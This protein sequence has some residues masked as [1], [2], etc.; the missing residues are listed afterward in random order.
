MPEEQ[1]QAPVEEQETPQNEATPEQEG[2][3]AA[4]S[5]EDSESQATDNWEE[6][7]QHLQPEY[8]RATQELSQYKQLFQAAQQGDP[9]ALDALGLE[10]A[11]TGDD[12]DEYLDDTERLRAELDEIKQFLNSQSQEQQFQAQEEQEDN[13]ILS[14]LTALESKDNTEL[15]D[16]E[17]ELVLSNA[18]AS[19][20][21]TGKPNVESAYKA[22]RAAQKAYQ[23]NYVQSKRAAQ[24]AV[25]SAGEEKIDLSDDSQRRDY[26]A[27]LMDAE[28]SDT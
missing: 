4:E 7:Y 17:T 1:Q 6:R 18:L 27:R 12:E 24:V 13:E 26:M 11:D 19:R 28:M 22:L 23:Q 2:T 5:Q 20:D 10:P 14:A 25:G 21:A 8:T 3:P 15:S 9:A 16:E